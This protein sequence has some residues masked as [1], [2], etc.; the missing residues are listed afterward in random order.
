MKDDL[1]MLSQ[2][3]AKLRS[4]RDLTFEE[5]GRA[6]GKSPSTIN[7]IER[8]QRNPSL[9]TLLKLANFYEVPLEY[10]LEEGNELVFDHVA[11]VL[12]QKFTTQNISL[13]DF[14]IETG[15]NY[16]HLVE[17]L[18]GQYQLTSYELKATLKALDVKIEELHPNLDKY[19]QYAVKY[20][21]AL[22][23]D[24]GV[25]ENIL[26]YVNEQYKI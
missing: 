2:R 13:N 26:Q 7:L 10:L 18:K 6:I 9:P 4:E 20:L 14:A 21:Q 17:T 23:L 3:L 1:T 8:N 5:V 12:E 11:K 16:F 24:Q 22:L 25:I 19:K 15:V